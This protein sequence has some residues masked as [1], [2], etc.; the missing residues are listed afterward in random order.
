[1]I[2]SAKL[3][4][5]PPFSRSLDVREYRARW[6]N[7]S[8]EERRD[9]V[10]KTARSYIGRIHHLPSSKEWVRSVVREASSAFGDAVQIPVNKNHWEWLTGRDFAAHPRMKFAD[11]KVG[12]IMQMRWLCP[13]GRA[14]AHTAIAARDFV[15]CCENCSNRQDPTCE[16]PSDAGFLYLLECGWR[17]RGLVEER[18]ILHSFFRKTVGTHYTVYQTP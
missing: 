12:M 2:V 5:S 11:I 13:D 15:P 8:P 10:V 14:I 17:K 18:R 6:Q 3:A 7:A 1:M 4:E 16:C 9:V